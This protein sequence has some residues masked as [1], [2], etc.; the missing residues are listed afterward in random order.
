MVGQQ[1]GQVQGSQLSQQMTEMAG[2]Q[3]AAQQV[4]SPAVDVIETPTELLVICDVPGFKEDNMQLDLDNNVLRIVAK[5]RVHDLDE[6]ERLLTAERPT[7][8][9]RQIQLPKQIAVNDATAKYE[10][11]VCTIH[12]P[13]D[14]EETRK[15]TQ[16]GFQ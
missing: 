6:D 7:A 3:G 16:I 2:Q 8:V 15:A 4:G 5:E 13:K 12:L 9:E 11:G 1:S 14:E 10:D